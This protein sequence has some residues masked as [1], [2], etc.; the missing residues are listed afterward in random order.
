MSVADPTEAPAADAPARGVPATEVPSAG[1]PSAG[2]RTRPRRGAGPALAGALRALR[3]AL[4]SPTGTP[5]T[6]AYAMVLLGTAIYGDLG[7]EAT[8]NQLLRDS[9][10]D[11]AHLA[12]RPLLVLI[13]SALWIAGGVFTAYGLAFP[14]V[15]GALERRVG[16]LRTAG[17]FLFGHIVATLATELPVAGAVAAGRLPEA[18]LHRLDYGVSFGVMACVGALAG[19]VPRGVKAALLGVAG[20]MCAADLVEFADPLASWGHP[21]ALLLG[22]GCW[23]VLRDAVRVRE[24]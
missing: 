17:V 12:E 20:L 15:L 14:F 10:T 22:M 6:F 9:S 11:A 3:R 2:T 21:V 8:V 13:A 7:D 24:S 23:P 18:S 19:F 16:G 1:M 4:P 5:F